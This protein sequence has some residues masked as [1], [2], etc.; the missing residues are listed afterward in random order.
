MLRD[1][2]RKLLLEVA[3]AAEVLLHLVGLGYLE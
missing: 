1:T 2:P 3:E